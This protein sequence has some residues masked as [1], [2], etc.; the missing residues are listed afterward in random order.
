MSDHPRRRLAGPSPSVPF[1]R[2]APPTLLTP[3]PPSRR[4]SCSMAATAGS[5]M[6]SAGTRSCKA[7]P[8]SCSTSA[9]PG[10]APC[11]R[12]SSPTTTRC[13]PPASARPAS[14]SCS[15][16]ATVATPTWCSAAPARS[17][18][19]TSSHP[20][21]SSPTPSPEQPSWRTAVGAASRVGR[22]SSREGG[23]RQAS[24]TRTSAAPVGPRQPRCRWV[25]SRRPAA[26]HHHDD[27]SHPSGRVLSTT[28]STPRQ[29]RHPPCR[30]AI[31][32]HAKVS[33]VETHAHTGVEQTR[34]PIITPENGCRPRPSSSA[35]SNYRTLHV[36]VPTAFGEV[37]GFGQAGHERLGVSADCEA[38]TRSGT[39]P[40]AHSLRARV[41]SR[42]KVREQELSQQIADLARRLDTLGG[43]LVS[44][45][46]DT[47][48]A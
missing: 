2:S 14:P 37:V 18:A 24:A 19:T 17:A 42:G 39:S 9:G 45:T 23:G 34:P 3:R 8:R 46:D 10:R 35:R 7:P 26:A 29:G 30:P 5:L 44:R 28:G 47:P 16:T 48:S 6:T 11:R 33:A 36:V 4:A 43:E 31:D 12:P 20:P 32:H 15:S 40:P 38:V 27:R 22:R 13:R 41:T 1:S 25:R 21:A